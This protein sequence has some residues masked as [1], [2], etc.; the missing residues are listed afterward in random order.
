MKEKEQ[1]IETVSFSDIPE[2]SKQIT[3]FIK[4]FAVLENIY[5]FNQFRAVKVD[6]NIVL[7]CRQGRLQ[8]KL[9]GRTITVE[10][11]QLVIVQS[12]TTTEGL[13]ASLDLHCTLLLI[14]N[15]LVKSL[16]RSHYDLWNRLL[17]VNHMNIVQLPEID[18]SNQYE[19]EELSLFVRS[20]IENQH[21]MF[22]EE[23]IENILRCTML[24]ILGYMQEQAGG[25]VTM[26]YS[27]SEQLFNRFLENLNQRKQR[28]QTVMEYAKE[29]YVS[30][31]Y[32][33]AV[34]KAVSG[35]NALQWIN[36]YVVEDIRQMLSN[37]TLSIKEISVQAGFPNLS[38][39]GKFVKRHLGVSPKQYR[40]S[41]K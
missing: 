27:Q 37:T 28:R 40:K 13:M 6:M 29:L 22:K 35:K 10:K 36:E 20:Y 24:N 11:G 12:G 26:P 9:S 38:F 16:L 31:K 23:I 1:T 19:A 8:F 3:M 17:Y 14:T 2:D 15:G 5:E 30:P 33:S 25:G 4:G 7:I 21:S 18:A 39:F 32:L 41:L 34:C